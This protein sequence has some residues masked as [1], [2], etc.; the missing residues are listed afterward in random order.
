[1]SKNPNK[2]G[3]IL[4]K[5]GFEGQYQDG[6]RVWDPEKMQKAKT[7]PRNWK[8]RGFSLKMG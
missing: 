8:T 7:A 5:Q 4:R 1:M 6:M 2:R 3:W